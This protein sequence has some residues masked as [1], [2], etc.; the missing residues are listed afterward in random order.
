MTT[1]A[2]RSR[3]AKGYAIVVV[4]WLA[5]LGV[6]AAV[7]HDFLALESAQAR[8]LVT[9]GQSEQAK[10]ERSKA[11]LAFERASLLAPRSSFVQSTLAGT[12][13]ANVGSSVDSALMWITPREWTRLGVVFGWVAGLAAA[14]AIVR[15]RDSL[16]PRRVAIVAGIA[17]V[18]S[19][20]GALE[21]NRASR[22]LA[23]VTG[24]TG[25][26]VSPYDGAGATGDLHPGAVVVVGSR[27]GHFLHIGGS[28]GAEGWVASGALEAVVGTS[29]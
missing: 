7:T 22:A 12:S 5:I 8:A 6:G 19:A 9:E 20:G 27:Y 3:R 10:G 11:A 13:A 24:P 16:A 29:I 26:L 1:S 14:I 25:I 21:S 15:R 4:V 17:F 23:V 28:G 2:N 18:L